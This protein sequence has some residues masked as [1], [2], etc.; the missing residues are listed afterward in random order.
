MKILLISGAPHC[1]KSSTVTWL[2]KELENNYG[3]KFH[4]TLLNSKALPKNPKIGAWYSDINA[5]GTGKDKNGKSITVAI[6]SCSDYETSGSEN[7]KFCEE[8]AKAN[9]MKLPDVFIG[10]IRDQGKERTNFLKAFN[11]SNGAQINTPGGYLEIP[12]AKSPRRENRKKIADKWYA[13]CI[14]N[15]MEFVISSKPFEMI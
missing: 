3:Y 9:G 5:F 14:E 10:T 12:L 2:M 15:L 6:C 11:L 4:I 7:Y 8:S 13:K 1:W